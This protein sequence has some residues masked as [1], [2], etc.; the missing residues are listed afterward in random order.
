LKLLL[1]TICSHGN[2]KLILKTLKW[3]VAEPLSTEDF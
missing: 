1:R 3:I 2:N